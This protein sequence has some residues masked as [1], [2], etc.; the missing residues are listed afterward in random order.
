M[1]R[2]G[3]WIAGTIAALAVA[4]ANAEQRAEARRRLARW[5]PLFIALIIAMLAFVFWPY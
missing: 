5:N 2:R 3:F 4:S 1:S